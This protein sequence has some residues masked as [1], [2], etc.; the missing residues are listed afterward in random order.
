MLTCSQGHPATGSVIVRIQKTKN[1]EPNWEAMTA[2]G[3]KKLLP[4]KE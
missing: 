2:A 4:T 1:R 3:S